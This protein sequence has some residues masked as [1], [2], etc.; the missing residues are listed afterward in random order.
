MPRA[1]AVLGGAGAHVPGAPA[2]PAATAPVSDTYLHF[3]YDAMPCVNILRLTL[4]KNLNR[5]TYTGLYRPS[6]LKLNLETHTN[7]VITRAK[8]A[9]AKNI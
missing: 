4:S 9:S 7:K 1:A 5:V 3:Y 2:V 8:K 6:T